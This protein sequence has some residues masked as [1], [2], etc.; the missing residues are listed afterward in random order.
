MEKFPIAILGAMNPK[1]DVEKKVEKP[2][3]RLS[4]GQLP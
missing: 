2:G 4:S 1:K 3:L